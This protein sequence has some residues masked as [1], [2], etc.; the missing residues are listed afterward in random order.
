MSIQAMTWA[1]SQQV[2]LEPI[3]RH[4]LLCLANYADA[5]GCG[6]YPSVATL[7]R[8]SGWSERAIQTQLCRLEAAGMISRASSARAKVRVRRE[9]R[10]PIVYNL[11]MTGSRGAGGA[12][13]DGHGVQLALHGV[14]LTTAR[15]ARGAPDP[16][17]I[18]RDPKRAQRGAGGA[19]RAPTGV[20][21]TL[22]VLGDDFAVRFGRAKG[23]R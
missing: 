7:V 12:P 9:D 11:C 1:L 4:V 8:D 17:E 3:G 13:R 21:A 14:H 20:Q 10:L 18:R 16:S 23:A 2:Y 15:G 19:P 22:E 5:E 6:A